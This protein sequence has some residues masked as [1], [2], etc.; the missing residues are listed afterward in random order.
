MISILKSAAA[1]EENS[2]HD[3]ALIYLLMET[4]NLYR[5]FTNE[6]FYELKSKRKEMKKNPQYKQLDDML[7]YAGD[8]MFLVFIV[9]VIFFVVF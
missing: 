9:V 3:M 1:K 2:P 5:Y 8:L 6:E 4:K 7:N